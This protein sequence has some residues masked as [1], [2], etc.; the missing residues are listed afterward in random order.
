MERARKDDDRAS[1]VLGALR[2]QLPEHSPDALSEFSRRL[3]SRVP[4]DRLEEAEP[5]LL[6]EQAARLFRLI[7]DTPAD[8]IGVELHRLTNRPHRAV[9]FTS[10]PDCAFIVETLQE[11]LAAE[12]YAILALLHPILSVGRDADG[13]VT[14]I[15][16]R[17]GSGSRTS[18]TMI[19][20]EGLESEGE[21]DLE[22]EVARRLGQVRLATTDF[23][24]MVED[25][26]RIRE[27][28]ESLKTDLDWKVPELQEIQEF[29]EWLRDGNFVF[30]GYR[31]YD[32][33]PG[34]D[35]ERQ[36]QLR[37]G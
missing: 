21:A 22:A 27:D 37:R 25:A 2:S 36:V 9:L 34:D 33:L 30:L 19:L 35:G 16:D 17:V 24:L 5:G 8:E 7:E 32:I 14:A 3:L 31:E 6:G 4:S 18:A 10:M 26:A 1:E 11:M 15:G 12:G 20:F 29:L 23:R 13:R 28:L